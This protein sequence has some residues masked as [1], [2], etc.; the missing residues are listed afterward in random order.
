M[1]TD[2]CQ[3]EI[4]SPAPPNISVNLRPWLRQYL[5]LWDM[6]DVSGMISLDLS[7]PF[8]CMPRDLPIAKLNTHAFGAQSL[9]LISN[10]FSKR[11]QSVKVGTN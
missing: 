2:L 9:R 8:D 11:K 4:L 1:L 7:K 10:Y 5:R 3:S 6:K